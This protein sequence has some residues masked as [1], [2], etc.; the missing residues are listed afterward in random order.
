MRKKLVAASCAVFVMVMAF[1]LTACKSWDE[2]FDISMPDFT[3]SGLGE[4]NAD[5]NGWYCVFVDDF[6][7]T[8]LNENLVLGTN[9]ATEV[10]T[11][12]IW[13]TSPHAVRWDSEGG[14]KIEDSSR[15]SWWCPEMVSVAD[16]FV[17]VKSEQR[18]NHVCSSGVC[19]ASGRFTGGIETRLV[20]S[21]DLEGT[22]GTEDELLFS[23]AFGYF[24]AKVKIPDCDGL[25]SAFW[26]QSSNQRMV[27]NGGQ[28]GTEIDVFESSFRKKAQK[29]KYVMGNALLWDG[30]GSSGK[31]DVN[32]QTLDSNLYDDQF[33]IFS[34]KWTPDCY[35]FYVDGKPIWA[36]NGGGVSKVA[37][38]LRLTVEIDAGDGYGPHGQNIGK[39]V[40]AEKSDFIIDYV[41]V[42]QNKKYKSYEKSVSDFSGSFDL[43]N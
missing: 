11:T 20:N 21:N 23:Q 37:E 41:K 25:W 3:N 15:W 10:G 40:N 39:F 13:T 24:E 30:Y 8:S 9:V 2:K 19:P 36:S 22:K 4:S 17:T 34:L 28:D 43:A 1:C 14:K 26:L 18:T 16:G 5:S 38:F 7:G 35:V 32:V 42:Y 33:H 29:G 27:G 12:N 31:S 6:D